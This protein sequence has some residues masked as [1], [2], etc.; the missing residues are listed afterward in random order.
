MVELEEVEDLDHA[1]EER[2]G[3]ELVPHVEED[4][5]VV[6]GDE[7]EGQVETHRHRSEENNDR[8]ENRNIWMF[9]SQMMR[10]HLSSPTP[11]LS[12]TVVSSVRRRPDTQT[13][14]RGQQ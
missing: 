12:P 4:V 6:S 11:V 10:S 5:G 8:S 14:H 13:E 3:Q 1:E 2:P 7:E 9:P